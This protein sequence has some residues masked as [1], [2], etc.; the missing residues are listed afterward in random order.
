[1]IV[2]LPVFRPGPALGELVTELIAGGT[3]A[4]HIVVVDDGSG[5]GA[6]PELGCT[7][8]THS[9]NRGK[10]AALK[11]G[12]AYVRRQHPGSDVVCADADGQHRA[13]DIR[14][15]AGH[16]RP[17]RIVLGVRDL[18]RMPPRSRFGNTLTGWL[19]RAMTGH[20]V[21]DTQTGLRGLPADLLGRLGTIPGDGFDYEMKMLV[22]AAAR[23]VPIDQVTVPTRYLDGNEGSHFSALADSAAVW[24]TLL[25]HGAKVRTRT[26][27]S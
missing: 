27:E 10:G 17:G 25:W 1:M 14:R 5:P 6:V 26:A 4:G 19:F 12:L 13:A 18:D 8:L 3:P 2:L 15:V 9:V 7:V 20:H 21:P 23:N 11:T 24:G 16:V 22:D